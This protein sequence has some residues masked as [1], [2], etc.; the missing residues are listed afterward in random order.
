MPYTNTQCMNVFLRELHKSYPDDYILLLVDNAAWHRSKALVV[1]EN[2]Q[3]Y[4][5]LPYTPEL[6]P[7][8]QIWDEIREKGFC[9][10][11]F[12]TLNHVVDRL[13]STVASLADMPDR[14][15]SITHRQWLNDALMF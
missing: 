15:A 11:V 8:E 2:I 4:P 3:L 13:C 12:A 7:I 9:N 6:N 5:L 1:P 10:E 14:V